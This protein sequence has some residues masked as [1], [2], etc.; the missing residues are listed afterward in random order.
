MFYRGGT[1]VIFGNTIRGSWTL[2]KIVFDNRRSNGS[3]AGGT[4]GIADGTS[5][6]DGNLDETG[7]WARDQI[8][9]GPDEWLWTDANPYPPQGAMP[10]YVWGNRTGSGGIVGA[11]V[12]GY[13]STVHIKANRDYFEEG[14]TFDGSAGLGIGPL[15]ARPA[16]CTPGVA[17]WATDQGTWNRSGRGGQGVL[18]KCVRANEWERYYEPYTYPH[19]LR[20]EGAAPGAP[21]VP[22]GLATRAR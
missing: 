13:R 19:P 17:Y 10:A 20:N 11:H 21:R 1:G 4:A 14:A 15:A 16:T 2:K 18:Y 9:R 5:P 6:W 7:W 8:G 12:H 3:S 22:Q